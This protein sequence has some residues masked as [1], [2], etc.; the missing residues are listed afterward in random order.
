MI[1][2]YSPSIATPI[3]IH[4]KYRLALILS[5]KLLFIHLSKKLYPFLTQRFSNIKI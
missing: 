5:N 4:L 2:S 3:I 1:N